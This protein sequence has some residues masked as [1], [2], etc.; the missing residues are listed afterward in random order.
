MHRL[1]GT[2]LLVLL[3][4]PAFA[5]DVPNGDAPTIDGMMAPGE[6]DGAAKLETAEGRAQLRAH[7][8][9]LCIAIEI[10]RPYAGERI[11][12][13]VSDQAGEVWCWHAFHPASFF[14][15]GRSAPIAPVIARR[16]SFAQR[17]RAAMTGSYG[18]MF[19]A[20]VFR[21]AASWSAEFVLSMEAL[22][23]IPGRPLRYRLEVGLPTEAGGTARFATVPDPASPPS[24]WPSLDIRWQPGEPIFETPEEDLRRGVEMDLFRE[25]LDQTLGREARNSLLAGALDGRKDNAQ[26]LDLRRRLEHCI[27]AD[28]DDFFAHCYLVH[29]LRRAN[30]TQDAATAFDRMA[31]RFPYAADYPPVMQERVA[32]LAQESR[33]DEILSPKVPAIFGDAFRGM[34]A[35]WREEEGFRRRESEGEGARGRVVL[36]TTKGR[37]TI[38]PFLRDQPRAAAALLALA[39]NGAL[40]GLPAASSTGGLGTEFDVAAGQNL[41]EREERARLGWSGTLCFALDADSG[42][43]LPRILL[44]AGHAHLSRPLLAAGRVTA[45]FDVV[46][47]LEASDKILS[48]RVEEGS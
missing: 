18:C 35:Q 30:Q 40:D 43:V 1:P 41:P 42:T 6:W 46:G 7:G 14:P 48:A 21:K 8:R 3:V 9:R 17:D 11:D 12:F 13:H 16:A 25:W 2:A 26:I 29:L 19:R 31:R 4:A 27:A 44:A 39:R 37:V 38:T 33:F 32:I 34:A 28:E 15:Q 10:D 45:G 22:N 23:V 5:L 47:A 36:E 24:T 20:R